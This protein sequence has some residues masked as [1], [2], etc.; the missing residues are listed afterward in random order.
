MN[1][2][3]IIKLKFVFSTIFILFNIHSN[4][5]LCQTIEHPCFGYMND[6]L[7]RCCFK[8]GYM[9]YPYSSRKESMGKSLSS[10]DSV[11]VDKYFENTDKI[12]VSYKPNETKNEG[13]IRTEYF[14][15]GVVKSICEI[16]IFIGI[17]T[18]T[19]YKNNVDRVIQLFRSIDKVD[20]PY[21]EF[22]PNGDL[23]AEGKG[24]EG[25][26]DGEWLYYTYNKDKTIITYNEGVPS[27]PYEEY[28]Y[29]YRDRSYQ[30]KIKGEYYTL[31]TEM[32]RQ[33]D[34]PARRKGEWKYY[35]RKGDLIGT[36]NYNWLD[37]K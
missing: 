37:D 16:V 6:E 14:E 32:F 36:A 3:Q 21:K 18:M 20:G 11:R 27:G 34:L 25:K 35:N 2:H 7:Q 15:N 30:I 4:S 31:E 28:F 1:M 5:A 24:Q 33:N 8:E 29:I 10:T 26:R 12:K 13:Y 9:D 22:Y 23:R 17:D 19:E